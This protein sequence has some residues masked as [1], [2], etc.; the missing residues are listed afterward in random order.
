M[1][2]AKDITDLCLY[3]W[4]SYIHVWGA[5]GS[6]HVCARACEYASGRRAKRR[7]ELTGYFGEH[8][9][10][11]MCVPLPVHLLSCHL[12]FHQCFCVSL[13]WENAGEEQ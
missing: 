6:V 9:N 2:N 5:G 11:C 1:A 4:R 3:R 10:V 13:L 8:L 12:T 7:R